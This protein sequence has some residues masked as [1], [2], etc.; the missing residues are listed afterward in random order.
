MEDVRAASVS[1]ER[2]IPVG[3]PNGYGKRDQAIVRLVAGSFLA[4]LVIAL[5][6][7]FH[8]PSPSA[9]VF[10]GKGFD[11]F[12]WATT[13]LLGGVLMQSQTRKAD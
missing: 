5:C 1:S 13:T 11:F 3:T 9:Y 6:P 2:A 7:V 8:E 12:A 10:L 4:L